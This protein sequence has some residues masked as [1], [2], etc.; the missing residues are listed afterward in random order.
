LGESHYT[1]AVGSYYLSDGEARRIA[2][3]NSAS[4]Y[5]D[6]RLDIITAGNANLGNLTFNG[7]GITPVPE[8]ATIALFGLGLAGLAARRRR[9]NRE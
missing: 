2:A 6:Y 1:L 7:V 5:Q 9:A 3:A 8:P 4:G